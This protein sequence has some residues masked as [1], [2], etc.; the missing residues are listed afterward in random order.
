[1][2]RPAVPPAK[3]NVLVR[4][5]SEESRATT[6]DI[7]EEG[8]NLQVTS[9][10]D[11]IMLYDE[12]VGICGPGESI[13]ELFFSQQSSPPQIWSRNGFCTSEMHDR[14]GLLC[15]DGTLTF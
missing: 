10:H 15:Q 9:E 12:C 13:S 2:S 3:Q 7:E 4:R 6:H 1:M 5:S 8:T 11:R 14:V